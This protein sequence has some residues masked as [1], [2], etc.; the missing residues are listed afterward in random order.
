MRYLI[1]VALLALG[2]SKSAAPSAAPPQPAALQPTAPPPSARPAEEAPSLGAVK[3]VSPPVPLPPPRLPIL[4]RILAGVAPDADGTQRK[5]EAFFAAITDGLSPGDAAH[6]LAEVD[7]GLR[8]RALDIERVL[9]RH[10][11]DD[12]NR[13]IDPS[14]TIAALKRLSIRRHGGDPTVM[15]RALIYTYGADLGLVIYRTKLEQ[16]KSAD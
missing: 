7:A 13:L 9:G 10:V 5:T 2:C 4:D 11:L 6:V 3:A 15:R 1:F 16:R 8:V 14:E 12:Y